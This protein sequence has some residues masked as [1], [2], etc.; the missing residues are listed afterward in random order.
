[1]LRWPHV[2]TYEDGVVILWPT[3]ISFVAV[4]RKLDADGRMLW[5]CPDMG[6]LIATLER[7][8]ARATPPRG[9][10]WARSEL[11][12]GRKIRA[13]AGLPL[14][15]PP[16]I[17]GE[18]PIVIIS[19]STKSVTGVVT[20]TQ[21]LVAELGS[22]QSLALSPDGRRLYDAFNLAY[23]GGQIVGIDTATNDVVSVVDIDTGP[24]EEPAGSMWLS[25]D[26]T[27]A[28]M[29][30]GWDVAEPRT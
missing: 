2:T 14:A 22:A 28:Y 15:R 20:D 6:D 30:T 7:I 1:M 29:A 25:V 27:K 13:P 24:P 9:T 18:P 5:Y 23:G 16:M 11:S 19:L 10:A 8:V 21:N 3:D 4:T 17:F 12:G 26:G